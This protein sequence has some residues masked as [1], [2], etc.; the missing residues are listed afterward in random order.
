MKREELLKIA[1]S[2]AQF[3]GITLCEN[4]Q[5]SSQ[6]PNESPG[7]FEECSEGNSDQDIGQDIGQDTEQDNGQEDQSEQEDPT[8]ETAEAM[9][10][11]A[12]EIKNWD[13]FREAVCTFNISSL[14]PT[15]K[16]FVDSVNGEIDTRCLCLFILDRDI[17]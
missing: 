14:P 15:K 9:L 1:T 16:Q 4:G 8:T 7:R 6:M 12:F 11:R 10:D 5:S 2:L 13:C 3:C 17:S